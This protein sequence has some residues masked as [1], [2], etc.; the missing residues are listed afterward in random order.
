MLGEHRTEQDLEVEDRALQAANGDSDAL[1]ALY[2]RYADPVLRF[3]LLRVSN[4]LVLAEDLAST[5]WER[6]AKSIRD[7]E[8]RGSGF[9]AW[10]FT[11]ARH[12]T[13]EY[14]RSLGR[15]KEHLWGE[16]IDHD[17]TTSGASTEELVE[18]RMRGHLVT[19][20]VNDLTAPQRKC[21]LLRFYVGLSLAET[22]SVMGRNPNAI[23]ALQHRA[24]TTL[25]GR[26]DPEG[27]QFRRTETY[28]FAD[29][30]TPSP[31]E[32]RRTA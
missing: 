22:A 15:S 29:E 10:L 25:A 9:P 6:V 3:I 11:I 20:A 1:G 17:R 32:V 27:R 13:Y 18:Q 26:V 16:M 19:E 8:T 4:N 23:K 31:G 21:V 7:Y 2:E 30:M 24:L 14:R 12:T 28:V 5:T